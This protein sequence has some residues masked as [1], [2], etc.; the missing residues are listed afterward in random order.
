MIID[1]NKCSFLSEFGE[2][3]SPKELISLLGIIHDAVDQ[4]IISPEPQDV[5]F[6]QS[7][8]QIKEEGPL[9]DNVYLKFECKFCGQRYELNCDT[10]HGRC[11]WKPIRYKKKK[12]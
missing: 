4:N 3:N 11:A 5:S 9:S 1:C 6:L 10:Y 7:Y 8:E 12:R 2:I